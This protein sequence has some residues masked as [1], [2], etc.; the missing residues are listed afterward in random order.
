MLFAIYFSVCVCCWGWYRALCR[1]SK[2]SVTQLPP[3]ATLFTLPCTLAGM[4]L[5]HFR[6]ELY[7]GKYL[8]SV[9]QVVT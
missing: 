5:A 8:A 6:D 4:S 1:L 3:Q 9:A 2:Y 7:R